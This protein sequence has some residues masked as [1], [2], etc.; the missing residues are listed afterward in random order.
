MTV[1]L[2]L[3]FGGFIFV[4]GFGLGTAVSSLTLRRRERQLRGR[5]RA[6]NSA[7]RYL[8]RYGIDLPA[9]IASVD[10]EQRLALRPR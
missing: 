6:L 2:L 4:A 7:R 10:D 8:H 1:P 9:W 5:I 3:L